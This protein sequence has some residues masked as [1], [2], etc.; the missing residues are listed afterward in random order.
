ME[1]CKHVNEITVYTFKENFFCVTKDLF[2]STPYFSVGYFSEFPFIIFKK[3][4]FMLIGNIFTGG[5]N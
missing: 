2:L 3:M 5:S 1:Y 4:K